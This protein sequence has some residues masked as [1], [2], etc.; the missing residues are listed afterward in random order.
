MTAQAMQ[1]RVWA[2]AT[3]ALLVLSRPNRRARRRNRAPGR[4]RVRAAQADSVIAVLR[5]WLPLRAAAFL[6]LPADSLSPGASPAQAASRALVAN[7]VMSPPVSATMTSAVRGPT[8]GMV[9]S[10]AMSR[11]NGAAASA[12]RM[13][14]PAIWAL[15]WSRA[16]RCSR[17]ICAWEAVNRPSQAI[18]RSSVLRRS[19]P[20][21]SSAS[22]PGLRSPAIS[23]S[24]IPRPDTPGSC[25]A[26]EAGLDAGVLQHLGQ[27]LALAGPL[28][29][30]L[31]AVPRPLP[32]RRHLGR[33]DE[34]GPQQPVLMQL[35]DPLAVRDVPL[36][37]RHIAHMR[38]VAHA[39]LDPGL[40][41][42]MIDRPPVHERRC[43]QRHDLDA[44]L[45]QLAAQRADGFHPRPDRPHGA[46][47]GAGPG[48]VRGSGAHHP[49]ILRHVDRGDPV[50]DPLVFLIVNHLRSAH[51]GL[52][53][54][55]L[56]DNGGLPGGPGRR[57]PGP[58]Y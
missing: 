17:H 47:P 57:A 20:R 50:M 34:A 39:H 42:R 38:R 43:F 44:V 41:Q 21:A 32:Q 26:T 36:A 3:A 55:G 9:I 29:D 56:L 23:A 5:C 7:R 16:S 24:I 54:W 6:R 40:R 27:P 35:G 12:T 8:P 14:S 1:I 15:R 28:P 53:C 49:G 45:L 18:C 22:R 37:A 2:T 10:R 46:A 52:L 31:L 11:A 33:R 19:T 48:R 4:L 51:R 58:E 30:E 13:S 25:D